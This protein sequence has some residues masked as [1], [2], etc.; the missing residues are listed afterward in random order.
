MSTDINV[1]LWRRG[2]F[3]FDKEVYGDTSLWL[4]GSVAS[5][6]A[7]LVRSLSQSLISGPVEQDIMFRVGL[8]YDW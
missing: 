6:N 7:F 8:P 3:L 4:P 1:L 2:A 5:V